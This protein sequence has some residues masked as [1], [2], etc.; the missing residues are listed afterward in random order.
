MTKLRT[1]ITRRRNERGF[2]TIW[3][4]GMC[5]IVFAIGGLGV[6]L[7]KGFTVRRNLAE[8]SDSAA[9]AGASRID[10][11]CFKQTPATVVLQTDTSA[12]G[13]N[14]AAVDAANDNGQTAIDRANQYID[15]AVAQAGITLTDRNVQIAGGQLQVSLSENSD[16]TLTRIFLPLQHYTVTVHSA[17]TPT[18][19][20]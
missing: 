14:G 12:C 7:W 13:T 15:D 19:V 11:S 3:V 9:V 16:T 1:P 4:L 2:F 6:D 20:G 10:I 18:E 8:I 5:A 17:A